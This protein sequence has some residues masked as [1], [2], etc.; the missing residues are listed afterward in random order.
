[1]RFL[2]FTAIFSL[3][4]TLSANR[5]P[6]VWNPTDSV[7]AELHTA[8]IEEVQVE[9]TRTNRSIA[10]IPTR[11]EVLT[12]EIDEAAS[13]EPSRIAH[14]L[15]HSTGIQVQTTSATSNA[16]VV[17]IQGL[18]GRYTQLLKDGFPMYG[19][20]SGSLDIMQIPPLDLRQVEYIKGS[21]STLYGGGAIGGLINLLSKRPSTDRL[22]H[23][24]RSHIG[25]SDFNL[26]ISDQKGKIGYTTLL[27]RHR[28]QIYDADEDGFSDIPGIQKWNLN[29]KLFYTLSPQTNFWVGI[30]LQEEE[31]S[32]G[33]LKALEA[34]LPNAEHFYTDKQTSS[35]VGSQVAVYH[36]LPRG[37]QI[38]LKNALNRFERT[39]HIQ[40]GFGT[41]PIYFSGIQRNSYSELNYFKAQENQSLNAGVN[42]VTDQFEERPLVPSIALRNQTLQT[43]GS[44]LNLLK[45]LGSDWSVESGLR[46]DH[47]QAASPISKSKEEW[48]LLPRISALYRASNRLTYRLGGGFG[49]RM[50]TLFNEESEPLGYEHIQAI[51][52]A[53]TRA[54]RSYGANFDMKYAHLLPGNLGLL[55][56]NQMFFYNYIDHAIGLVRPSDSTWAYRQLGQ[57]AHSLGFETQLKLTIQRFTWFVGYTYTDAFLEGSSTKTPAPLTPKHS[58]KGDILYVVAGTWRIGLDYDYKSSQILSD[59]WQ[60]PSLFSSGIVVERT[61]GDV[62]I[63]LNAEN[64]TDVRQTQFGSLL[65]EPYQT[66][67]Y[68]EIWAPLDGYFF[69]AGL[70]WRW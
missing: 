34:P 41:K 24:N 14:L 65:T 28:H 43:T 52:Y 54:E 32:G 3:G 60:T 10:N 48:F 18:N 50:P 13:M 57:N 40:P 61:L 26:F 67:Q 69:N 27:S 56:L 1:M 4:L 36:T 70:K 63:F 8:V 64:F 39:V 9:A 29:T 35:R 19:G 42:F 22:I 47:V 23:L 31:R 49:Y 6:H 53:Q 25:A 11:T 38:T 21:A 68:T 20:F 17:R 12:E 46:L 37:G 62:V 55:T 59:G 16:A 45:D 66:P 7:E 51:D 2:T 15:T 5:L 33:D 58:V 44:Y 30:Q